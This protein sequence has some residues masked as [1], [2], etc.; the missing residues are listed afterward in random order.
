MQTNDTLWKGI[1]ES[2]I[3]DF[4]Y[5]FF[6]NEAHLIDFEKGFIFLDQELAQLFPE[7]ENDKR[8][9]D[10]LI[11]VYMK[12]GEERW[13]LIHLEVQ[14]YFDKFFP[15]RMYIYFY[16]IWERFRKD[17]TS[18]AIFTD[19]NKGF[20]PNS[21][22]KSFFGTSLVFKYPFYKVLDQNVSELKKSNNPFAIIILATLIAIKKGKK[23]DTELMDIKREL[24][25]LLTEKNYDRKKSLAIIYF[26][27]YYIR[28]ADS[29]N[30]HIF[31]EEI[32]NI[33]HSNSKSMGI[34]EMV[35]QIEREIGVEIG[36][37]IGIGKG[38]EQGK[39]IGIEENTTF[40]ILNAHKK[41]LSI[42]FIADLVQLPMEKVREIIEKSLN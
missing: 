42:D 39:S 30:T 27:N 32:K 34:E 3:V 25:Q 2:L 33:Y 29:Q 4:L 38:I 21:F 10:K 40:I 31:A 22:K 12:T 13:F 15:E 18:L 8:Y 35:A 26:I 5:F 6:P 41:G 7:A 9:I 23:N 17:I 20:K 1:I 37:E 28:F 16:R 11:Q 24:V 19:K 14:G 36:V